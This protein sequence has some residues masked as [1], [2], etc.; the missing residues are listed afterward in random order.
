MA[1]QDHRAAAGMVADMLSMKTEKK[2]QGSFPAAEIARMA[3]LYASSNPP[4]FGPVRHP[5]VVLASALFLT[6]TSPHCCMP[7]FLLCIAEPSFRQRK[8]DSYTHE[9]AAGNI[10]GRAEGSPSLA[11]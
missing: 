8:H 10:L 3:E 9:A 2:T 1:E 5:Q 4:S 11:S 6:V 7:G